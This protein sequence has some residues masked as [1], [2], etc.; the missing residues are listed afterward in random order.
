MWCGSPRSQL[1]RWEMIEPPTHAAS[2]FCCPSIYEPLGL[3]NLEAMSCG[4]A[5][6]ASDVGGIPEVVVDG[7]TGLLVP[8]EQV[9]DGTGTPVDPDAFVAD[10]A[11]AL[12]EA[13]ADR[14]RARALRA[15]RARRGP[16]STSRGARSAT[17]RWPSTSRSSAA[18]QSG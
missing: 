14:E 10:L 17:R 11:G 9:D 4:T 3:V 7:E 6:V 15:G 12:T 8:F 18:D 1:E 13:V 2:F 5:V 16:S